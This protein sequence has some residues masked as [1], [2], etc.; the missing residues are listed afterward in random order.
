MKTLT[1][2]LFLLF[3]SFTMQAQYFISFTGNKSN[4]VDSVRVTNITEPTIP[5]VKLLG[6]QILHLLDGTLGINNKVSSSG[7][8]V[9]PNP[10]ISGNSILTF[11]ANGITSIQVIDISGKILFS[12][13]FNLQVGRYNYQLSGLSTGMYLV[14]VNDYSSKVVSQNDG[15]TQANIKFISFEP[16]LEK[17]KSVKIQDTIL[18]QYNIGDRLQYKGYSGIMSTVVMDVPTMSKVMTFNFVNCVDRDGRS[19]TTIT[20][21]KQS[22]MMRDTMTIDSVTWMQENLN[23]GTMVNG[24]QPQTAW[25]KYCYNNDTN[26]CNI[27]GGLYQWGSMMLFDTTGNTDTVQGM[28]PNGFRV[29]SDHDWLK[30]LTFTDTTTDTTNIDTIGIWFFYSMGGLKE[31]GTSHWQFPNDSATNETGFTA[32]P[33]GTWGPSMYFQQQGQD[34]GFNTSTLYSPNTIWVYGLHYQDAILVRGLSP[35][36]GAESVRCVKK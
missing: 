28:C 35:E 36:N 21:V 34:I 6:G 22:K 18:M 23:V 32:L 15:Q 30:L 9:Y 27:Y 29:A 33:A 4:T 16:M 7:I 13:T 19:Y 20:L 11:Q 12:N 8:S 10:I 26:N 5:S 17:N 31:S 14:R 1:L 2:I 3:A 25:T 24:G